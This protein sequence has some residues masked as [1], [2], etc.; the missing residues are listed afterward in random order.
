MLM[1][2]ILNL[3]GN[4]LDLIYKNQQELKSQEQQLQQMRM[5]ING[6]KQQALGSMT[7]MQS[8]M[9][10]PKGNIMSMI[11]GKSGIGRLALV[12][13][14]YGAIAYAVYE[15]GKA[16]FETVSSMVMEQFRAGGIFVSYTHLR[17]HET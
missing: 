13:G 7:Q 16:V 9:R 4:Y 3:A 11:T 15:V 12:G 5:Q 10:N 2:N 14:I 17:A 6:I 1:A 8:M